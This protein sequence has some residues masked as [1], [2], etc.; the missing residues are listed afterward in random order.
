MSE[1][2]ARLPRWRPARQQLVRS[3]WDYATLMPLS[4][5]ACIPTGEPRLGGAL[6]AR[7]AGSGWNRSHVRSP[8]LDLVVGL[9]PSIVTSPCGRL[10]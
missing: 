9:M 6:G 3:C 5:V 10:G 2:G 4:V 7:G 1:P 8:E